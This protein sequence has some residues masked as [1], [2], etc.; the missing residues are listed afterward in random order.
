M[1]QLLPA[2]VIQWHADGLIWWA[3][4]IQG[5]PI[6]MSLQAHESGLIRCLQLHI[7]G[8]S[9]NLF[10]S[11]MCLTVAGSSVSLMGVQTFCEGKGCKCIHICTGD[12]VLERVGHKIMLMAK[13]AEKAR[14]GMHRLK[15][16]LS[17]EQL[18]ITQIHDGILP[19][20]TQLFSNTGILQGIMSQ[21]ILKA[22]FGQ[23]RRV[24]ASDL[25]SLVSKSSQV[26]RSV[27]LQH[28]AL[29]AIA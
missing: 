8:L 9:Q 1:R 6:I 23:E 19:A 10:P 18:I 22:L 27:C 2:D 4:L 7:Q 29:S 17:K 3:E 12:C 16:C 20:L 25:R 21:L 11:C 24:Q 15:P 26:A 14:S 13:L 28:A 5:C